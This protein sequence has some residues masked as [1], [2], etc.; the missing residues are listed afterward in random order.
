MK[1]RTLG[2]TNLKVS[3]IGLG[4]WQYG[5]EWGKQGTQG[6]SMQV[7]PGETFAL[8]GDNAAG[9]STLM[10]ILTGVYQPDSGVIRVNGEPVAFARPSDS[11]RRG[12]EMV[13][14]DFALAENL[15]IK[16]NIFLGRELRRS[17]LGG[18]LPVLDNS[19]MEREANRVISSL[20]L[21][22]DPRL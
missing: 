18:L 16:S 4:T 1:Y 10:K 15:D 7:M 20:D 17:Y 3:V 19:A 6:V 8:L 9:K 5:G 14:Q 22:M 12:I 21:A 13:Y 11:R 2:K